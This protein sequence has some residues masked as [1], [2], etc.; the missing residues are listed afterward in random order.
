M[1][2]LLTDALLL[3]LGATAFMDMVALLQKR[4]LG[5]PR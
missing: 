1:N 3:G 4:L 2:G 5:I